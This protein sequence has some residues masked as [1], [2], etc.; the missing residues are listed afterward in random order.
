LRAAR[1]LAVA[2]KET[3]HVIR[4]PRSLAMGIAIPLLLMV[5][6]G[7]A[8]STDVRD[9]PLAVW[10]RSRTPQ[11][12]GL[13]D[14]LTRSGAFRAAGSLAGYGAVEDAMAAGR[15]A[16][17][18]V[19][20][21][22][23]ADSL[24][25]GRP[26]AVQLLA[27]GS[28][29][30]TARLAMN[31]ASSIVSGWRWPGAPPATQP[32]LEVSVRAWYNP[33]LESRNGIVPGL[34]AVIL[35]VIAALLTSLSVA[36]EWETGTMEQLVST[37]V[38]KTE[39]VLGKLA[40]YV[41][42][43][44]LDVVLIAGM[45]VFLLGV[46]LRGSLPFLALSSLFFVTGSMSLG[47]L[48]SI[49]TRRQLL[50]SQLAIVTTF[51]PAFLLSGFV[52]D[53]ASMPPVVQAVTHLVPARY[54]VTIQRAVFLKGGGFSVLWPDLLL[55]AAYCLLALAAAH[56]RLRLSLGRGGS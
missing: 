37:P 5:L 45:A 14:A 49:A 35:M 11:S 56:G 10:D 51:L 13:A 8:L 38:E 27:D 7:Y 29:A 39:L 43:G 34:A 12:R 31:Y 19:I 53:I 52:F 48:I 40:P 18:L 47:L 28:D 44:A 24:L 17:A 41:A 55:M 22:G 16:A 33:T 23:F 36:R 20:P 6:F 1:L 46:P 4:D 42:V 9:L 54:F 3:L 25:S 32:P 26:T 30:F 21:R 50:A 2:R 15:A